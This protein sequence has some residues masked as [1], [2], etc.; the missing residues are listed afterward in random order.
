[1]KGISQ[2]SVF[3]VLVSS[4]LFYCS[5]VSVKDCVA[6][7]VLITEYKHLLFILGAWKNKLLTGQNM[8]YENGCI[9]GIG[10]GM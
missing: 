10:R 1:M 8:V 4:S 3:G 2:H 5:F 6:C 9:F 7:N